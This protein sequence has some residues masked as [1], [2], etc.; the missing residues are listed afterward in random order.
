MKTF[1]FIIILVATFGKAVVA[2]NV[3]F[4]KQGIITYE[5]KV[6]TYAIIKDQINRN[7]EEDSWSKPAFENYQKNNSQFKTLK[8]ILTFKQNKVYFNPVQDQI[9]NS[10]WFNVYAAEQNNIILSDFGE[11]KQIAQKKIFEATYLLTDSLKK[12]NWKITDEFREIAGYNC[13][14]ANAVIM[15]SIYVVAFYTEKIPLSGG[16]ESFSGLPGMILGVALPR[17]HI[18][19]FATEVKDIAIT[20]EQIKAPTKGKPVNQAALSKILNDAVED[21]KYLAQDLLKSATL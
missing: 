14:R 2:Q 11:G 17:E 1:K 10:N 20:E 21:R 12:I 9:A 6:N 13:R 15:D 18:T 8:S 3:R 16:P 19:W 4:V 7:P 5:K